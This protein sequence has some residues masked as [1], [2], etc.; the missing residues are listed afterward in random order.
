MTT[1]ETRID[2]PAIYR[3]A[4]N[5]AIMDAL[6][7]GADVAA[8]RRAA[9]R[10]ATDALY[11]VRS[12]PA[13]ALSR[14]PGDAP[15]PVPMVTRHA[16]D[17]DA[18]PVTDDGMRHRA[19]IEAVAP[20]APERLDADTRAMLQTGERADGTPI[21][22]RA[23]AALVRDAGCNVC[24]VRDACGRHGY[25]VWSLVPLNERRGFYGGHGHR[26][27]ARIYG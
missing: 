22:G 15:V 16:Y 26:A 12:I 5:A 24:P 1:T 13:P 4:Y 21:T 19:M 6:R 8:A 20:C 2:G 27:L 14:R 11:G 17:A 10:I 3:D 9:H 25:A 7:I 18:V 23:A